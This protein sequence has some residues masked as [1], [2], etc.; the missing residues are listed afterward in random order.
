M[1]Q[2]KCNVLPGSGALG[3]IFLQG[4][5]RTRRR[6]HAT[7]VN[8]VVFLCAPIHNLVLVLRV[9]SLYSSGSHTPR[10]QD[11]HLLC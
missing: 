10:A 11:P 3:N 7:R 5:L 1:A 6:Q 4:R 9:R 2:A 8:N